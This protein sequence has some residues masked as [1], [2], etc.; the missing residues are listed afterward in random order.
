MSEIK[1]EKPTAEKLKSLNIENWS[2]WGCEISKFDWQ[3]SD[4][5]TAYIQEGHVIVET[6]AG[7]TEIK[8][9]DLVFFPKGLKCVWDVKK[10]IKKVY[11]FG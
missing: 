7:N 2:S 3:Y 1:V 8:A 9:G 10:A 4:D 5:E 11:K 6:E